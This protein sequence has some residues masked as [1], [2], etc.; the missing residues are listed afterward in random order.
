MPT[1]KPRRL[2]QKA[3]PGVWGCRIL[4]E[5]GEADAHGWQ[6]SRSQNVV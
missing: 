3:V 2:G 6:R 1:A 5:T 4:G